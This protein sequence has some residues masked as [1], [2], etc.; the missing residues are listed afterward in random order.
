MAQVR[1][2]V[3]KLLTNV[4]SM[5]V[6]EGYISEMIFPFI[7]VKEKTGKL[8]KYGAAHQRIETSVA[9]GRGK[10]RRVEA[11]VRSDTSYSVDSHG[12][13]S[14]VSDDDYRNVEK[15]Y[16]AEA[17]EVIGVTTQLWLEKEFV[18]AQALA[19]TSVVT[20]N[21]TLSGTS[22]FSD[23]NNSSPLTRF[24]AARSA[25][26]SGCG[27]APDTAWMSWEVMNIL[28]FHPELLDR[29]GYKEARPGGLNDAE[30]ARAMEVKRVLIADVTYNTAKEGQADSLADVWGKH[31]WFGVCPQTA[32]VRQVSAGYR[33]GLT[34]SSPRKVYKF[35]IVNPPDSTGILVKDD[36]SFLLSNAGALYL[37]KDAIA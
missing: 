30:L 19:N 25:V 34:G 26:R 4:S 17:D 3:D 23:Y 28:K 22:Q 11:I 16:D 24:G 13:E 32:Q 36:Y 5:H 21:V 2:I 1:S 20:Q 14:M 29:L 15:P 18:L 35:P 10:F 37:L 8:A 9:G 7:G 33:L 31:L 6:P 27:K 12:L